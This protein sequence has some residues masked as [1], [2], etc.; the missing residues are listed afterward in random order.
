[1]LA[2]P[3]DIVYLRS[4]PQKPGSIERVGLNLRQVYRVAPELARVVGGRENHLARVWRESKGTHYHAQSDA[5]RAFV[6][7]TRYRQVRAVKEDDGTAAGTGRRGV[8][9]KG[10]P[11]AHARKDIL[12][13][14]PAL[15]KAPNCALFGDIHPQHEVI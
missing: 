3:H 12:S 15:L 9:R 2:I 7:D 6:T 14:G 13:G 4:R 8:D 5:L 1:M 11:A 10:D